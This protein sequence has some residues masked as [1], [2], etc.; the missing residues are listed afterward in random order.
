MYVQ[1]RQNFPPPNQFT[2]ITKLL[3]ACRKKNSKVIHEQNFL[4]ISNKSEQIL[5][6]HPD[7]TKEFILTRDAS[8]EA[9]GTQG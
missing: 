8:D 7:F 2:R 1:P 3:T 9:L 4:N 5:R 6:N